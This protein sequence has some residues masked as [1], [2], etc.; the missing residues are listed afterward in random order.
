MCTI[1]ELIPYPYI[2]FFYKHS[3]SS[4]S[5]IFMDISIGETLYKTLG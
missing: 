5:F 4:H 1:I 3:S 2:D